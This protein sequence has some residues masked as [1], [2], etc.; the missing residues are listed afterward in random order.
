[1]FIHPMATGHQFVFGLVSLP[2]GQLVVFCVVVV[3][4]VFVVVVVIFVSVGCVC[5]VFW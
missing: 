4:V 1:M 5:F 2:L 3:V